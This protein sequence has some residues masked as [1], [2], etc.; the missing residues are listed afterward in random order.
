MALFAVAIAVLRH[1]LTQYHLSDITASLHRIGWPYIWASVAL[2]GLG[3][4]ALVGYD[5]LS[6]RIAGHPISI[7]EMW[8]VSFV[9][10]A[11]QN[12]APLSIVAGGGLR[13]RLFKR[14]GVSGGE[15][16]AV[17]AG[18]LITFVIGLFFV[19]GIS[20]VIAPIPI[21][22]NFHLPIASLL[23]VGVIFLVLVAAALAF[24]EFGSGEIHVGRRRLSLPGGGMLRSQLGVSIAD[25]LLSSTALYVLLSAAG[26]VSFFHFLSGFLLAQIVT[27]V[28]PL[29]G[30]V[31]VFEAAFL[32]MR[33]PGMDASLA[34]AALLVYRAVYYLLP[35]FVAALI[36]ALE[37]SQK[38]KRQTTPAARLAREVTPHLFA[39]L[40]FI[41]GVV[42]LAYQTIPEQAPEFEWLGRL[43]RLAVIEGSHF[44]GSLVGVGLLLLAFGLE[45]QLRSAFHLTIGLLAIGI[46]AAL[47]RSF[48]VVSAGLLFALLLLL[49]TARR[50]FDRT[51]PF[52]EEPLNAGWSAAVVVAVAGIGW[53]GIYL[54]V[55]HQY[56]A[57]LWWRFAL[58]EDVPRTLRVTLSVLIAGLIFVVT[59]LVSRARRRV[60]R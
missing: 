1:I 33:P 41:A 26:P 30:G 38:H 10:Y 46:P 60:P 34:T 23:P 35:L 21:P 52:S 15:T 56:T 11:V 37:A 57:A 39:V 6:L 59:R 29:P 47:L 25:W 12:S 40:T 4:A 3:Y 45:R 54:Q 27:Q 24:A 42:L 22:P 9:S 19:A 36:L 18:N 44:I 32:L 5:Y 8:T 31:G 55:R 14:L 58:D 7:R 16:A 51:I 28:V 50:E 49:L 20:F 48:D 53:L 17:I 13:Y 43:L 2:T